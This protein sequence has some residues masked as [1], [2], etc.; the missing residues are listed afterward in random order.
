M[1]QSLSSDCRDRCHDKCSASPSADQEIIANETTAEK[2]YFKAK[3][4]SFSAPVT[5]EAIFL[6]QTAASILFA[7]P[8]GAGGASNSNPLG[9]PCSSITTAGAGAPGT[10][11]TASTSSTTGET[12]GAAQTAT[13]CTTSSSWLRSPPRDIILSDHTITTSH[14]TA[15]AGIGGGG[16]P[17]VGGGSRSPSPGTSSSS[18]SPS[19]NYTG[20]ANTNYCTGAANKLLYNNQV[21][22]E[23]QFNAL[24]QKHGQGRLRWPDGRCYEGPF[25][26]DE[27]CGEATMVWQDGR[28]YEG[29]YEKGK[30][31]GEGS[32]FWPDG[33]SYVGQ[34]QTGRRHG[35]GV[36]R[37]PKTKFHRLAKWHEDEPVEWLQDIWSSAPT[38]SSGSRS[39]SSK[40]PPAAPEPST[41]ASGVRTPAGPGPPRYEQSTTSSAAKMITSNTVTGGSSRGR[42][43]AHKQGQSG[44]GSSSGHS[45]TTTSTGATTSSLNAPSPPDLRG[46]GSTD[47][48]SMNSGSKS[49]MIPST[50]RP[51]PFPLLGKVGDPNSPLLNYKLHLDSPP[52]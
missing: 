37:D 38:G 46:G 47:R 52:G 3:G 31:H 36:Y 50:M 45:T 33:R 22:Y 27:F 32:F 29:Q 23:G 1:G 7:P 11:L 39:R 42:N 5:E 8:T 24:G 2:F 48:N 18:S 15:G 51:P 41:N 26:N 12:T 20:A 19:P 10:T 25:H 14:S 21:I 28:K 9:V 49:R 17:F 4:S 34:W 43:T 13:S 44:S 40:S 16:L 35:E 30:K 6:Q